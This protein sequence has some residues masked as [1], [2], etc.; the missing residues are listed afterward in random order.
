MSD[1]LALSSGSTVAWIIGSANG[2]G[3]Q[4]YIQ[5]TGVVPDNQCDSHRAECY[6]IMGGILTWKK[7][8]DLWLIQ[9]NHPILLSCDNES[10]INY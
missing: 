3:K 8:R 5:G 2:Y 7:Y 6:G 10:A 9:N 4:L 1:G